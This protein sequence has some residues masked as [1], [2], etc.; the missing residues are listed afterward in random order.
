MSK[1]LP[2]LKA[3]L[4]READELV[5]IFKS[6]GVGD[7]HHKV[8]IPNMKVVAFL[9]LP[10]LCQD[11]GIQ[12]QTVENRFVQ[13]CKE[14]SL[15]SKIIV[16]SK[17]DL[18]RLIYQ[19]VDDI[20]FDLYMNL[21]R[22]FK[23]IEDMMTTSQ[24]EINRTAETER[25]HEFIENVPDLQIPSVATLPT[26][27]KELMS[28]QSTSQQYLTNQQHQHLL[29]EIDTTIKLSQGHYG[30]Q[31]SVEEGTASTSY[32]NTI[33]SS[34]H[35]ESE[36]GD[37]QIAIP[38]SV[39]TTKCLNIED[40]NLGDSHETTQTNNQGSVS[41]NDDAFMQVSSTIQQQFPKDDEILVSRLGMP[42]AEN[43]PTNSK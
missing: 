35:L 6:V 43:S 31:V 3:M 13:N 9:N 34:T 37:G 41:L 32:A 20:D 1:E 36:Y 17:K 24:K 22:L 28:E 10:S 7:D 40:V 2:E 15:T 27:S 21:K 19:Q 16:S 12:F 18:G 4:I 8:E 38:L 14:L 11:Q 29:G 23:P 26:N 5:E 30:I 39:S 33:T 42:S 25:E